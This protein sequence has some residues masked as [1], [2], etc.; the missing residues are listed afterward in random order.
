VRGK[1]DILPLSTH[2]SYGDPDMA[3]EWHEHYEVGRRAFKEGDYKGALK[4]LDAVV[5]EKKLFPDVFNMLGLIYYDAGRVKDAVGC[6]E[7]AIELNPRY[8]E[9]SLNLS[10][11]YN[12]LREYDKAEKL[13]SM[14]KESAGIGAGSYLDPYVKA[15]LANMH[16]E[17][18]N[19][20]KDLGLYK[21]AADEYLKGLQMRPEFEDIRTHLGVVYRDMKDYNKSVRILDQAVNLNPDYLNARVQLGITY[22]TM[23]QPER[24]RT[25]WMKVITKD[26]NNKLASMYLNLLKKES[27]AG[28]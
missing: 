28:R 11:I 19:I 22:F 15:R 24:A 25:E 27:K 26:P 12:E 2:N 9:A 6:F 8:T 23:G 18:G 4:H 1:A 7:K 3:E 16:A 5:N 10:V 13:Y 21:E 14:A 17:L 20:Y